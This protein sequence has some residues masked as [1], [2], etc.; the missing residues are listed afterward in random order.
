MGR[1]SSPRPGALPPAKT[2]SGDDSPPPDRK[3]ACGWAAKQ[4]KLRLCP[5]NTMLPA[6]LSRSLLFV[7]HCPSTASRKLPPLSLKGSRFAD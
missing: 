4:H 5:R 6:P 2:S 7:P 1:G 3:G